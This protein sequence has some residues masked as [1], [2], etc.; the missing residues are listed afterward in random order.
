MTLIRLAATIAFVVLNNHG[1][2]GFAHVPTF[3]VGKDR[4]F[5][6]IS[7]LKQTKSWSKTTT[8]AATETASDELVSLLVAYHRSGSNTDQDRLRIDELVNLLVAEEVWFD[9]KECL[10]GPLF[11]SYVQSGPSPLWARLGLAW[12]KNRQGQ[13]Y[14]FNDPERGNSVVNYAE[15]FGKG[16]DMHM[17]SDLN[18]RFFQVSDHAYFSCIALVAA[19]H[20]R[21]Y[22]TYEE[23]EK[24]P[25]IPESPTDGLFSKSQSSSSGRLVQCPMDYIVTVDRGSFVLGGFSFDIPI[26]GTGHLRVLYADRRL[27]IFLSPESTTDDRWEKAGLVV[28][29]IRVDLV[30]PTLALDDLGDLR[31]QA[32]VLDSI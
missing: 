31:K 3:P 16:K 11:V 25:A 4:L 8:T 7:A 26:S 24:E 13:Q 21:A 29:Q 1:T 2:R 15:V 9:P 32:N 6:D 12:T 5:T 10:H 17:S 14:W 19:L 23:Q 30:D 20:V 22:G 18:G 27:R 28:A